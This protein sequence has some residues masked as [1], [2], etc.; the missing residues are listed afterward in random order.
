[1]LIDLYVER[2]SPVHALKPGV[3]LAL[4]TSLCTALFLIEGW[5]TL[6]VVGAL[7]AIGYAVARLSLAH[8]YQS[9]KPALWMLALIFVVQILLNN[10]I[11]A[12]YV[13]ARFAVMIWAASLVT[14]TTRSSEMIEGIEAVLRFS[15]S[16]VPKEKIALSLAL[17]LRFIPV[18]R[19]VFEEVRQ[20]QAARGLDRNFIALLIPLIVRTLK[21]ADEIAE[22]IEARSPHL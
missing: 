22:A 2:S 20:A 17:A 15:P 6:S 19:S 7:V 8:A 13:V 9:V 18:V 5:L 1:M 12:T 10:V 16:W 11:F 14:L 3:K 4:L 21:S